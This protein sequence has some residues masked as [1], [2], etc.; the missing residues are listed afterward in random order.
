MKN[1]SFFAWKLPELHG[2]EAINFCIGIRNLQG[3]NM[4]AESVVLYV[5]HDETQVSALS[6]DSSWRLVHVEAAG[7]ARE[8]LGDV[9]CLVVGP[10]LPDTEGVALCRQATTQYPTMPVVFA[11]AVG[12]DEQARAAV[13]AGVDEYLP[14]STVDDP[15]ELATVVDGVIDTGDGRRGRYQTLIEQTTDAIVVIGPDGEIQYASMAAESVLGYEP[16]DLVGRNGLSVVHPDDRERIRDVFLHGV[17]NPD[18]TMAEEY[19]VR[20]ADGTVR[21]VEARARNFLQDPAIGGIVVSVRDVTARKERERELELHETMLNTVPDMVYAV[22]EDGTFIAVNE[23]MVEVTGY[24]EDELLGSHVSLCM[25]DADVRTGQEHIMALLSDDDRQ[26]TIYEMEINSVDGDATPVENHVALLTDEDGQ[27]RGS[28]GVLRDVSDRQRRERRL[29]VLNRA[30]RHDLRNSMHVILANADLV[31]RAVTDPDVRT[32]LATIQRRAEDINSLSEKAREIEGTIGEQARP[33]K[34]IDI[35]SLLADQA[36]WFREQY[37]DATIETDIPDHAWVEAIELV[38]VAVENLIENSIQ[39][40]SEQEVSVTV[41]VDAE[42]VT[43]T[44][45]DT[46]PGIPQKERRVVSQGSET[47]LDHASGLGL[48]LVAWIARDSGGRIVFEDDGGGGVVRLR[49]DRAESADAEAAGSEDG[50][51]TGDGNEDGASAE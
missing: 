28:V 3:T 33:R 48:W 17:A 20:R 8:R 14:P 35:A 27:F 49:F 38:D 34:S 2:R 19:R 12:G 29:T 13:A 7:A 9:A 22:D 32:K 4:G 39:H 23:T 46:G 51:G 26:K 6:A 10:G 47:P 1:R 42:T 37:P 15:A 41:T 30:L 18:E 11:P 44:V 21:W 16:A 36:E 43:V 50:D 24:A 25:S 40:T 31:E 45:S 5:G